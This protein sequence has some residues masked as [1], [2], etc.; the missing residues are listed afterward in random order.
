MASDNKIEYPMSQLGEEEVEGQ[1]NAKCQGE[2]DY[3]MKTRDNTG[4]IQDK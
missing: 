1:R 4:A 2:H 3:Q